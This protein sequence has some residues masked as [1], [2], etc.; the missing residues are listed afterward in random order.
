MKFAR[1]WVAVDLANLSCPN[2]LKNLRNL[3]IVPTIGEHDPFLDN[4]R[5]FSHLLQEKS[6]PHKLYTWEDRAHSGYYWRR[7]APLNL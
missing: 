5:H 7:M 6:L 1:G 2:L 3:N 4:E